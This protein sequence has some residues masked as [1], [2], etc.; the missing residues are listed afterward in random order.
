MF[1]LLGRKSS[2][3]NVFLQFL[4]RRLPTSDPLPQPSAASRHF[5][6]ASAGISCF[7]EVPRM[8]HPEVLQRLQQLNSAVIPV[9]PPALLHGLHSHLSLLS[10]FIFPFLFVQPIEESNH[11]TGRFP[12]LCRPLLP[13]QFV[14]SVKQTDPS[15]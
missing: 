8:N 11:V 4:L 1:L 13:Q 9:P 7:D 6:S 14:S 12:A 5:N 15:S 10:F 2:L 3:M